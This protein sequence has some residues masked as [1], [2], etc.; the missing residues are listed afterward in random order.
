MGQ[1]GGLGLVPQRLTYHAV[2]QLTPEIPLPSSATAAD[3][4]ETYTE[5][6]SNTER[7]DAR[8]DHLDNV[9]GLTADMNDVGNDDG[10]LS[11]MGS[12]DDIVDRDAGVIDDDMSYTVTNSSSSDTCGS[13]SSSLNGPHYIAGLSSLHPHPYQHSPHCPQQQ[14]QQIRLTA[15]MLERFVPESRLQSSIKRALSSHGGGISSLRGTYY[16]YSRGGGSTNPNT[17]RPRANGSGN[18]YGSG[19]STVGVTMNPVYSSDAR[20]DR[21]QSMPNPG[22]REDRVNDGRASNPMGDGSSHSVASVSLSH[23]SDFESSSNV[24]NPEMNHGSESF[25]HRGDDAEGEIGHGD[26]D[27]GMLMDD[28]LSDIAVASVTGASIG[29]VSR[30]GDAH[31]IGRLSML[32]GKSDG[33]VESRE[34][35]PVGSHSEVIARHGSGSFQHAGE[36]ETFAH[37]D[38]GNEEHVERE[39]IREKAVALFL[40]D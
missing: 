27:E 32:G 10:T 24:L 17:S 26:V 13:F 18:V 40:E 4:S 12:A 31:S 11:A 20:T 2:N 33:G 22:N 29:A 1:H 6:K 30:A 5:L 34:N 19:S 39:E 35:S 14:E 37:H 8:L 15:E 25:L 38:V 16:T 3:P 23:R 36:S 7:G 21:R 9:D 28:R